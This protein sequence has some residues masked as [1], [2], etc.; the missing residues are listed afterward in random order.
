MTL[1]RQGRVVT[2][3]V[4][5]ASGSGSIDVEHDRHRPVVHELDRPVALRRHRLSASGLFT[6]VVSWERFGVTDEAK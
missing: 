6:K 1:C 4:L 2:W 3:G 5:G